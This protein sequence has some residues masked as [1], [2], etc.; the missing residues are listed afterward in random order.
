METWLEKI[1]TRGISG[2]AWPSDIKLHQDD[3]GWTARRRGG[4]T[5][6]PEAADLSMI[7]F[8]FI[9]YRVMLRLVGAPLNLEP[10]PEWPGGPRISA[11]RPSQIVC[12]GR[13]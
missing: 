9:F 8:P 12:F 10:S 3:Q 5:I 6:L 13:A 1:E 11:A 2:Q 4:D 7:L